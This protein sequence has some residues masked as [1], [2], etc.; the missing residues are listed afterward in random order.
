[1]LNSAYVS[2]EES[3]FFQ[4]LAERT[5]IDAEWQFPTPGSNATQ[6]YTLMLT[7]EKLPHIIFTNQ[8][9]AATSGYYELLQDGIIWDLTEYLPTYAPDL[10]ELV[11][12]PEYASV[13]AMM[14]AEDGRICIIP[15]FVEEDFNV[16]YMGPAVRKD[17]LDECGLQVPVT[18]ED[19]EKMLTTFKEKYGATY[20]AA[21]SYFSASYGLQS[22][23]GAFSSLRGRW[24]LDAETDEVKFANVQPEWKEYLTFLNRW[25]EAGLIDPDSVS[26][27]AE[28]LR[29]KAL[30][31]E[32]GATFVPMSQLT[33]LVNDAEKEGTGAEW[34][35]VSYPRTAPGAEVT[36]VQSRASYA[37][38]TGAAITKACSEEQLIL[39]LQYVNY[40]FT[41]EGMKYWNYG[42]EGETYTVNGDG[43]ISW[44][45]LINNDEQGAGTALSKYTGVSASGITVQLANFVKAKNNQVSVDAVYEWVKDS[46]APLYCVPTL[47][48]TADETAAYTD[49][50]NAIYSYVTEMSLKF[51]TG[52]ESLD[53][54]DKF[55]DKLYEM[56]LQGCIDIQNASYKR[57][58]AK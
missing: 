49:P 53:N 54:F 23:T 11:N 34:I 16:T 46:V 57:F 1:M 21:K 18:L 44:T 48:M 10:W 24:Y 45:D 12:Q 5:G 13:L 20:A 58:A 3:P 40:G 50:Y 33:N 32:V 29:T 35:G 7:E 6:A 8:A 25:Y 14:K 38:G 31:N 28:A 56:G 37:G 17:W 39:A 9:T 55:V 51:L 30:N 52:E 42:V 4:G 15:S 41:E 43:T 19:W 36:Y 27:D 47:Q 2:Y 22:G 26:M